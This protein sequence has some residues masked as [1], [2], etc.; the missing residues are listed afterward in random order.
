MRKSC[1]LRI[2]IE[3]IH[4]PIYAKKEAS[5][6]KFYYLREIFMIQKTIYENIFYSAMALR[7]FFIVNNYIRKIL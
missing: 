4:L 6:A 5:P 3:L 7:K 2:V 1:V